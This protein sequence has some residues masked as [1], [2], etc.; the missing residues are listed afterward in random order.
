[1]KK[2]ALFISLILVSEITQSQNSFFKW[3][4]SNTYEYSYAAAETS[5]GSFIITGLM[6]IPDKDALSQAYTL[7]IDSGGEQVSD[8]IEPIVGDTTMTNCLIIRF[9]FDPEYYY[10]VSN[11]YYLSANGVNCQSVRFQKIDENLQ[12]LSGKAFPSPPNLYILPQA[13]TMA[14]DS[15]VFILSSINEYLPYFHQLGWSV[16][17]YNMKPDSLMTYNKY[18]YSFPSAPFGILFNS[19][20]NSVKCFEGML[21]APTTVTNLDTNLIFVNT[22]TLP[23]FITTGSVAIYNDSSYLL[24]GVVRDQ[25]NI[26]QHLRIFK[27]N[28]N[29]DTLKSLEYYNNPDTVLY[30]G[31][32]KNT[33]VIG[34]KIFVVGDYNVNPTQYPWQNSPS[35]IQ[36]TRIDSALNVIDH[37]FYGGDA[38]YIP[39]S[40]IATS[41]GGA[42]ITGNRYDYHFPDVKKFHI[43]ALKINSD[44]LI[45]EIPENVT[46]QSSEI[47]IFPNPGS[48]YFETVVGAQYPISTLYLYNS[49]GQLVFETQLNQE[50]T[51][52]NTMSLSPGTYLYRVSAGNKVI[53]NGKWVKK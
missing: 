40:I 49:N 20:F 13:Y 8:L 22:K 36:I 39:Y 10:L 37:H 42:L 2:L 52:I 44:G 6:R 48:D 45:T 41:D 7:K 24:T 30:G 35:W 32:V 3:Y 47:I 17:K 23:S 9:P 29:D 4:P 53:G 51:H 16:S 18:Q 15:L 25:I 27:V 1:M 38:F 28:N 14:Y 5:D 21:T 31:A 34:D 12:L 33:A 46:W 19:V 43:F 26:K 50:R 11:K